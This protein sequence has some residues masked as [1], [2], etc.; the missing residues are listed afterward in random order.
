MAFIRTEDPAYLELADL[1]FQIVAYTPRVTY[2]IIDVNKATGLARQ[3]GIST[4]GEVV[5]QSEGRRRDFD[6]SR[7]ELLIPAILQISHGSNKHIY[8]TIGHGERHPFDNERNL[9]YS[10]WRNLLEQNNYQI[11]SVSLFAGGVPEDAS[12]VIALGP[13]K[14]F[15]PEELA[16]LGKYLAH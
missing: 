3:Y 7:A 14:D 9:G 8:F 10:T 4:Y 15:L 13:R 11:D 16:A 12:V 1:L 5:V 6:N 2:Q